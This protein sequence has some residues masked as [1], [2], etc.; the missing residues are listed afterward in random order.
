MVTDMNYWSKVAKR[1]FSLILT[2]LLLLIILK[3]SVFYLPFLIA[4]VLALFFE[5]IIKFFMK[6]CKWTRRAS[7]IIVIT[8]S[9]IIIFSIITWGTITLF[10]EASNLLS[11]SNEY[12]QK[13]Q[14]LINQFT[15]NQT[16]TQKLPS[17]ILS[18]MQNAQK[19]LFESINNGIT[20][21][22]VG[23]KDWIL[24]IPNL[25]MSIVFG[26][27]A[28]YFMCTDK[29]YMID[30]LEHHLPDIWTKKISKHLHAIIQKLGHYL[31][32]EA[33]L[34][35]ISFIISLIGFT[36]FNMLGLNVG[37]PL[38]VSI[39][40]S[41]VDALP[42]LG[43]GAAMAP[44]AVIEA[45][46]GNIKLGI[47]IIILWAIMGAVRNFLEPKLVS[48]NIGIHPV[49]TLISMFTGYKI[50]GVSGMIL[51]PIFLIVLKEIYTPMID[52]GV[53]RSIFDRDD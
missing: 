53:L 31:K 47:A 38:L 32:A 23:I 27:I 34:I 26:F 9:I 16:L 46:N 45:L 19:Q 40:I 33:T 30:Q 18:S 52:K 10:N 20:N 12:Y 49:F 13:I 14:E 42:I 41:F 43:S 50:I 44:W 29:I 36:I 21:I 48:K 51:G 2:L 11:N 3:L 35:F 15:Q 28:L 39:G 8:I 24:K 37:F 17:E 7:S 4:F 1:I 5:P 25:V 22:L 6:K